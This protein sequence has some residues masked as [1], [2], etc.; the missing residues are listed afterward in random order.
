M[1]KGDWNTLFGDYT[2]GVTSFGK[3]IDG[4]LWEKCN[5]DHFPKMSQNG[6]ISLLVA[7]TTS[8]RRFRIWCI[9]YA[10]GAVIGWCFVSIYIL[11]GLLSRCPWRLIQVLELK[12]GAHSA[13]A[14]SQ[15]HENI[16]GRNPLSLSPIDFQNTAYAPS[17]CS[18]L[19]YP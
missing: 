13:S 3:L 10:P 1:R 19:I 16:K 6:A 12:A 4:P 5:F 7:R 11:F 15:L 17:P 2:V 8:K 18:I 9:R 14:S